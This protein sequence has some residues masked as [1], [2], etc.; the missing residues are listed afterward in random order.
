MYGFK[1]KNSRIKGAAKFLLGCGERKGGKSLEPR[2]G[3][4]Q[5]FAS[6]KVG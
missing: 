2:L 1:R 4:G 5:S 6:W 3:D